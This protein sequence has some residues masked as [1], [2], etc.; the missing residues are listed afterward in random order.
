MKSSVAAEFVLLA[1][2]WGAS[3]MFMR[4]GAAEFGAWATAGGRVA[5]ASLVLLPL[6]WR[7]GHIGALRRHAGH[8][9]ISGMLSSGL[10]FALYSY[11]V[12]SITTGLSSILNATTPLFGALV[13]WLWLK[14]RPDR[15]RLL[16]LA[17]GFAGVALLSWEKAS[18]KP[19]GTGWAVLACLAAT[20]CYG[21]AAN[22]AKRFL[23]GVPPLAN[24]T[25]SQIGASVGLAVP[26]IVYWPE[27]PPGA[28]AWLAIVA[29]A[30]L[31]SAVAYI[32]YFRLIAKAGP[33]KAV[34]VTFM[35]PLFAILYGTVFLGEA[36]TGWM[37]VCG[38]V[39]LVGIALA[40]GLLRWGKPTPPGSNV[41]NL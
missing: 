25:G 20:L 19:G 28:T 4:L 14:D 18:F 27:Q 16:G 13:A 9:F 21:L 35:I 30:V 17:L 3:F 10:P 7:S 33:S 41:N 39:I 37:V 34:T 22:H 40:T 5:L 29:L 12:L 36:L 15:S 1:A 24:A 2:L 23:G 6:L 32:L 38:G 8:L 26:T 11:A 31:C